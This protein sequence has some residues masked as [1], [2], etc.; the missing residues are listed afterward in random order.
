MKE[1][2]HFDKKLLALLFLVVLLCIM[3]T[4]TLR[5]NQLD[6]R[7]VDTLITVL[8]GALTTILGGIVTLTSGRASLQRGTDHSPKPIVT[9]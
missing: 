6:V 9:P 4:F 3:L 5:N 7:Y 1:D 8:T 2:T